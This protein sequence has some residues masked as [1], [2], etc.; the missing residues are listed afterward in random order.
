MSEWVKLGTSVCLGIRAKNLEF[1]H[2]NIWLK[3]SFP[4]KSCRSDIVELRWCCS[5]HQQFLGPFNCIICCE[6]A[7][8][9]N[10]PVYV[11]IKTRLRFIRLFQWSLSIQLYQRM[12]V[13]GLTPLNLPSI[14]SCF[15]TCTPN[16]LIYLVI[17]HPCKRARNLKSNGDPQHHHTSKFDP[18][19]PVNGLTHVNQDL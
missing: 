3:Q 11:T 4:I 16:N 8:W 18:V 14:L 15:H 10:G 9:V 17:F 19:N 2:I 5:L 7:I 1:C 6:T 13:I 12:A